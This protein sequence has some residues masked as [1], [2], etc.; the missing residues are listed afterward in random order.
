MAAAAGV[1]PREFNQA[2]MELGATVCTPRAPLCGE[3]PVASEC[4]ARIRGRPERYPAPAK[5]A[6]PVVV[7]ETVRVELDARGLRARVERRKGKWLRGIWDFPEAEGGGTGGPGK[8]RGE[9][10]RVRIRYVI[11]R[12]R[13]EREAVI[14][15]GSGVGR[16][17]IKRGRGMKR[18]RLVDL[19]DPDV[20]VGSAFRKTARA[21]LRRIQGVRVGAE[22][23]SF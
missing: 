14:V 13:I 3:C 1:A 22:N 21:V 7:R 18:G 17:G 10:G 5:K 20:A 12:H 4:A 9:I 11:T 23:Q 6:A 16:R 19:A 8:V 15:K 2:L